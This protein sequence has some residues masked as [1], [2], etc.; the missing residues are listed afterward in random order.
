MPDRTATGPY[1]VRALDASTWDAFV[2][3]TDRKGFMFPGCW[4]MSH[5]PE[6]A[7]EGLDR[8]PAMEKRVRAGRTHA[9][10]VFDADGLAQGWAQYGKPEELP[11]F[12]HRRKYDQDPPPPP[13][14][15][16]TC[17]VVDKRHRGKGIAR[18]A[19]Q[20]ALDLI[21][22]AGGGRIEVISGVT[23]GHRAQSRFLGCGTV[24]L[25]EQYGFQRVRQIGKTAWIVTRV[26]DPA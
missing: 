1:T 9:A 14:W 21:A 11:R 5:H 8:R 18:A 15:R 12:T 4:C 13:D 10:L 26:L 23:A 17:I 25:F 22:Q 7:Q 6:G 24:E 2:E 16:I 19:I 3:L 20:G